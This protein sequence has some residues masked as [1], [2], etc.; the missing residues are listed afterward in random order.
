M[1]LK[2]FI[3]I[4]QLKLHLNVEWRYAWNALITW[5]E[6]NYCLKL[7]LYSQNIFIL[8]DKFLQ[9]RTKIHIP[10]KKT[11]HIFWPLCH[12]HTNAKNIFSVNE[13]SKWSLLAIGFQPCIITK[14]ILLKYFLPPPLLKFLGSLWIIH[15]T[16]VGHLQSIIELGVG[17]RFLRKFLNDM[18]EKISIARFWKYMDNSTL[19]FLVLI[20][21]NSFRS[22]IIHTLQSL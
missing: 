15:N 6:I 12:A 20:G 10:V 1:N 14:I 16:L 22:T 9:H 11:F 5:I 7:H 18:S 4:Q 21:Y 17:S 19:H 8:I 2:L 13:Y 3:G